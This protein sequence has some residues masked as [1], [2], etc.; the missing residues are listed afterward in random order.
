MDDDASASEIFIAISPHLA[1]N[2]K[3]VATSEGKEFVLQRKLKSTKFGSTSIFKTMIC[4]T[5]EL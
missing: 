2:E 5:C 3:G 4:L 1:F